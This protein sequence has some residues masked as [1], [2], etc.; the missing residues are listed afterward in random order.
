MKE[1]D[2]TDPEGRIFRVRIPSDAPDSH[3]RFGIIIGPP[4]LDPLDLPL[5]V[6]VA[7]N[8]QLHRRK[9][10][11]ERDVQRRPMEV[12][13]AVKAAFNADATRVIA[14]YSADA[15]YSPPTGEQSSSSG[16]SK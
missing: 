8:N 13:S 12:V 5:S 14:L 1:L 11:T 4:P 16:G 15:V 9:L 3:A 10:W 7:L 2:W 6:E